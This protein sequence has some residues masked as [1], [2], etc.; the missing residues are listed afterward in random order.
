MNIYLAMGALLSGIAALMHVGCIVYGASWYRFFGAGE[1][2]AFLAESGSRLPTMLTAGIVCVLSAWSIYALSGAGLIVRLP[3]LIPVLV[4]VTC[5]Y[6]L[7]GLAGL[8]FI[9]SPALGN[10][11]AFWFWSSTI[12]L[13]LGA[14]HLIGLVQIWNVI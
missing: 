11:S 5:V 6:L 4:L 2:M 8:F 12:C 7:R 9:R 10:T 14:V 1:R 13:L 3:L